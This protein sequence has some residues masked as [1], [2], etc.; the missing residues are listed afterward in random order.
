MSAITARRKRWKFDLGS[1]LIHIGLVVLALYSLGPLLFLGFNSLKSTAA[2]SNNPLGPPA[3]N[4]IEWQNFPNAWNLG[5]YTQT[6]MNS[7]FISI[8]TGVGVMFVSGLAAYSLAAMKPVGGDAISL[9]FMTGTIVPSL[10]YMV[11]L[12]FLWNKLGLMG[13]R[14]GLV[15]IYWALFSPFSTFLLRS[16]MVSVPQDFEDAAKIDGASEWQ[17][18]WH[19]FLPLVMP[20]FMT[21]GLVVSLWAWN[22]FMFAVTF[23]HKDALKPIST[24]LYAFMGRYNRDWGLTM[25][26]A[27]IM[28][29]P[30]ITIFLI[31]QRR[32]IEGLTA[33]GLK[34]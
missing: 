3:L 4:D 34:N 20:G 7:A 24:S 13:T 22:E 27:V 14:I 1:T 26:A 32:F 21:V 19:V 28:L 33:G 17:T 9:Y 5:K 30:A 2:F 8:L 10:L 23:L 25:A 12:F 6:M 29:L 16:Y 11:P 31:F 15:I 18:F